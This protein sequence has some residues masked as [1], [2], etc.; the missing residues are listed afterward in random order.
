MPIHTYYFW[1]AI[2]ARKVGHNDL[3][4]GVWSEFISRSVSAR[5]QLSMQQVDLCHPG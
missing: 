3:V 2:L 5:L 4:F 1:Q